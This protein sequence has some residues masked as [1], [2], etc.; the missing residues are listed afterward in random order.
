L[1]LVRF[2][3][4]GSFSFHFHTGRCRLSPILEAQSLDIRSTLDER[5][6]DR[7]KAKATLSPV[8]HPSH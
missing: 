5:H 1:N 2:F 3:F 8:T 7:G 6:A 4:F